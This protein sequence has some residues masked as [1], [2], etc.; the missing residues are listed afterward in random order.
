M[1]RPVCVQDV[2]RCLRE[3]AGPGQQARACLLSCKA[4]LLLRIAR[5][6]LQLGSLVEARRF[7]GSAELAAKE[8]A[9]TTTTTHEAATAV[10][11][12]DT[13]QAVEQH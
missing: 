5:V 6:F 9:A 11:G 10:A 7:V 3:E 4:E 8:A 1:C 13:K 12:A 2:E